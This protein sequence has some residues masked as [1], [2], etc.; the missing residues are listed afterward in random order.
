MSDPRASLLL[1]DLQ[2]PINLGMILRVAETFQIGVSIYDPRSVV[3]DEGKA[4]TI[5]DFACGALQRAGYE[6]ITDAAML[7]QRP[8][9]T[10]RLIATSIEVDAQPIETFR[11]QAGDM[12]AVGNEYDGLPDDLVASADA[13]VRI[14]M[15]DVWTP[16][17]QSH[18]PIDAA[19]TAP[20]A[21]D[22]K[23]NLNVA[24]AAGIICHALFMGLQRRA[25]ASASRRARVVRDGS[26]PSS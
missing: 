2:S 23:P 15:G 11:F 21:R 25:A 19:R 8:R 17:P 13:S 12:I 6:Q 26:G 3:V 5:S 1:Y 9:K 4:K 24:I 14:S 20:V 18:N 10:R 22:G 16:K 7:L